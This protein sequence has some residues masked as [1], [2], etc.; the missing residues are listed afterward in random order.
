MAELEALRKRATQ[1]TPK[2][3]KESSAATPEPA[4]RSKRDLHRTVSMEASAETR[5]RTKSIRITVSFEDG[6]EVLQTE[7]HSVDLAEDSEVRSL[8]V[9]LKISLE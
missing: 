9:D 4:T 1:T 2:S 8:S 6:E 5:P 3:R 7:E